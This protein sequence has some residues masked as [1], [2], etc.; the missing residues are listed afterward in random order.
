MVLV[1][2]LVGV[3]LV[4]EL[5]GVE[6]KIEDICKQCHLPLFYYII[7]R[8]FFYITEKTTTKQKNKR[9]GKT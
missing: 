5:V 9:V 3:V 2:E 1:V 4:V 8:L 7:S 6:N